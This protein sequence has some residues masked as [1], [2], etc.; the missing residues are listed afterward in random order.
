V[1]TTLIRICRVVAVD[2]RHDVVGQR[3]QEHVRLWDVAWD[4]QIGGMEPG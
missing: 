4:D 1:E 2:E 3:P